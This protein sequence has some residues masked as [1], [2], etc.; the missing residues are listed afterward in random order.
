M[1]PHASELAKIGVIPG[2]VTGIIGGEEASEP[3][4]YSNPDGDEQTS[5]ESQPPHGMSKV[6]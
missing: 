2:L 3:S 6:G 5:F 4:T 1:Y